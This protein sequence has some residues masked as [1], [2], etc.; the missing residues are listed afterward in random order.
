RHFRGFPRRGRQFSALDR[1]RGGDRGIPKIPSRRS[2][3]RGSKEMSIQA[4]NPARPLA[5][6]LAMVAI[7]VLVAVVTVLGLVLVRPVLL[8]LAMGG[9]VVLI[10]TFIVRD[11]RAYWLFL[12]VLSM[13][14]DV[15]KRTT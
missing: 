14:F 1:K 8:A 12:L 3:A 10:P 2:L 6:G 15:Y 9:I 7:G 5:A 4:A 13:P 11:E